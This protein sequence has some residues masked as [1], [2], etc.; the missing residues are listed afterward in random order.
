MNK[1]FWKDFLSWLDTASLEELLSAKSEAQGKL[2]TVDAVTRSDL[3]RMIRLISEELVTR[4]ELN[5]SI[6]R[7]A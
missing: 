2:F 1:A 6:Q 4:S 3:R 5:R 7:K